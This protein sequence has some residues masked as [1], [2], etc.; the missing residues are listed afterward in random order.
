MRELIKKAK[1][2][3]PTSWASLVVAITAL[4]IS[5]IN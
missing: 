1:E 2:I 4:I 5:Y 3:P